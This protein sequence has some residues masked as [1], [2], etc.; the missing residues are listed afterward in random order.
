MDCS[1]QLDL[2]HDEPPGPHGYGV[3]TVCL[4]LRLV[5]QGVSLRGVPRVL[6][7]MAEAFGWPI[8]I[9]IGRRV[10]CG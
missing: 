8:A 9:P 7:L 4:F 1:G 6:T 10:G 2:L 3:D 5:L